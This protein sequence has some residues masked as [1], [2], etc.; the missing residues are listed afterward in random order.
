MT[1]EH[2][3][4]NL[5]RTSRFIN[6]SQIICLIK[7]NL[8][9]SFLWLSCKHFLDLLVKIKTTTRSSWSTMKHYTKDEFSNFCPGNICKICS[10]HLPVSYLGQDVCLGEW[11]MLCPA[12]DIKW[13][14]IFWWKTKKNVILYLDKSF[15]MFRPKI[16]IPFLNF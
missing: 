9:I 2:T 11:I 7:Y 6:K 3:I 14:N 12:I 10:F 8:F 1:S 16:L 4:M 5:V 15:V 13:L